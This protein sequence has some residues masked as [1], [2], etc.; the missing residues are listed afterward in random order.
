MG[1]NVRL[2]NII[3]DDWSG[4]TELE[5]R[6]YTVNDLSEEREVLE[7]RSH[8][9]PE[10]CFVLE[11]EHEIVGYALAL[12]YPIFRYPDLGRTED[13]V[14][15]SR[16]LHLHDFVIAEE[17]QGRGWA[18]YLLNHLADAARSKK[19]ERISLIAVGG[20]KNFWSASG[21]EP[22]G[23]VELAPSYGANAVYMSMALHGDQAIH[24]KLGSS[25]MRGASRKG[26]VG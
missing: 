2:R 24:M 9:S 23:E 11:F 8:A 26:E 13:T 19:Y 16:N 4:I 5:S 7:S 20:S 18:T 3:E 22:Y 17:F 10:T 14:F 1:H 21:Y 6:T 15:R 12:P 25:P